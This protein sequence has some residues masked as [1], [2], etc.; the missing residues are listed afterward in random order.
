MIQ[1]SKVKKVFN[2][3]GIQLSADSINMISDDYNRH[4]RLMA[5]R[6]KDGNVKRL[7]PDLMWIALGRL[8]DR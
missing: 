3:L 8:G 4:I 5:K 1:V 2:S 6:C 7:T